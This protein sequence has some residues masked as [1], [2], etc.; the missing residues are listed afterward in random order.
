MVLSWVMTFYTEP[1]GSVNDGK[2]LHHTAYM[3]GNICAGLQGSVLD[4]ESLLGTARLHMRSY[5]DSVAMS[6][7]I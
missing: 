2:A 5:K 4:C 7:Y 1:R 6:Y 3:D